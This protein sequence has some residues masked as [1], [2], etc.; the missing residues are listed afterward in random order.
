MTEVKA[1]ILETMLDY[2]NME[3]QAFR[4][5]YELETMRETVGFFKGLKFIWDDIIKGSP[6]YWELQKSRTITEFLG[7]K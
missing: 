2:N 3:A 6:P 5:R 7:D 4:D 1:K